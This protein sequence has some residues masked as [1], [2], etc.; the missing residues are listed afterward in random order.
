[1]SPDTEQWQ[2][3]FHPQ[4]K[5]NTSLAEEGRYVHY[6]RFGLPKFGV[7]LSEHSPQQ[8]VGSIASPVC[9]ALWESELR[10]TAHTLAPWLC[11]QLPSVSDPSLVSST[12]AR[13]AIC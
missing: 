3:L 9:L 5:D 6:E 12:T 4:S 8:D 2:G 13:Q 7:P 10:E 11:A 1:M